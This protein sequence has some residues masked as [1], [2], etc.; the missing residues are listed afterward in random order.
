MNAVIET[1]PV[2]DDEK[3][4]LDD[5]LA[6]QVQVSHCGNTVWVYSM[7]GSTIGRFSKKFGMDVHTTATEQMSGAGE[8]IRCTHEPAGPA[9][10]QEFR[11]LIF[12]HYGVSVTA[13]IITF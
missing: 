4:S 5:L 3:S 13:D 7:D 2:V 12:K 10:W 11:E 9:Q 1:Q 6:D 8:C